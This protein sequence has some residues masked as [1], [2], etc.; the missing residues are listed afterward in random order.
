[1]KLF[2]IQMHECLN[3]DATDDSRARTTSEFASYENSTNYEY[4]VNVQ[5]LTVF[6]YDGSKYFA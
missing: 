5:L 6:T 1:M 3:F 4:R 2:A